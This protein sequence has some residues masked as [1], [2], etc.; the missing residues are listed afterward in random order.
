MSHFLMLVSLVR[1]VA[2]IMS[3]FI[4]V[5]KNHDCGFVF[6]RRVVPNDLNAKWKLSPRQIE[7][8]DFQL[9][10]FTNIK[11]QCMIKKKDK[12]NK[13]SGTIGNSLEFV[14]SSYHLVG[15]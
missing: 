14:R 12:R 1:V 6:K 2:V 5:A 8:M 3:W 15:L 9:R 7:E 4:L 11:R 10:S 13:E